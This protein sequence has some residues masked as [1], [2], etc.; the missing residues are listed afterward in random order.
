MSARTKVLF[1]CL[2]NSCRSQ[3]AEGFARAYGADVM[4]VQSAGLT[5]A[6]S[7][8]ALTIKVMRRRNIDMSHVWPKSLEEAPGGPFDLIVNMSGY[9]LPEQIRNPVR[10]WT[11]K[12]PIAFPEPVYEEVAQQIESL[13]VG[14][15]LEL[16]GRRTADA[17]GGDK[18][19]SKPEQAQPE[20]RPPIPIGP[21]GSRMDRRRER[22]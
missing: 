17:S 22:N 10:E 16:R 18:A 4:E 15:V 19:V 12:D 11:V 9:A 14:L 5:P 8:S 2:G 13:V 20:E 1:V 7:V 6:P 3:M 21:G